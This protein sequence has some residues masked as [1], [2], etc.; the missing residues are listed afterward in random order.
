[1]NLASAFAG[2]NDLGARNEMGIPE[3]ERDRAISK[4]QRGEDLSILE[5][6]Q[7]SKFDGEVD[8]IMREKRE[9]A[10]REKKPESNTQKKDNTYSYESRNNDIS[11]GESGSK[12]KEVQKLLKEFGSGYLKKDA[13]GE[14]DYDTL[15][16]IEKYLKETRASERYKDLDT[17]VINDNL[18]KAL[19]DPYQRGE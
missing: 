2:I 12:V 16:A 8:D 17:K 15:R 11:Y 4:S 13:D 5:K 6:I 19:K 10:T 9:N 7:K 18:I 14:F 1:M 3:R